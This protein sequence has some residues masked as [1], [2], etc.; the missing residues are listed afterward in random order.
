MRLPTSKH[1]HGTRRL[2]RV[3][4]RLRRPPQPTSEPDKMPRRM[5]RLVGETVDRIASR[6]R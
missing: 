3:R 1:P 4:A 2:E 5:R 6:R